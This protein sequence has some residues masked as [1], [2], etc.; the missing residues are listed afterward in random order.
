MSAVGMPGPMELLIVMV[1][2]LGGMGGGQLPI[3]MPPGEPVPSIQQVAPDDCLFYFGS[4]GMVAPD[5][6]SKNQ[7]ELMLAEPEVQAFIKEI[8]QTIQ[9]AITVNMAN[10]APDEQLIAQFVYPFGKTMLT[11]PFAFFAETPQLVEGEN[12]DPAKLI[13]GGFL[14][15]LGDDA[16]LVKTGFAAIQELEDSPK[17]KR[18][19]IG[20]V[21]CWQ[22]I[23]E[24][25]L[26]ITYGFQ[27]SRLFIA[28]GDGTIENMLQRLETPAPKWLTGI[29]K[30]LPVDRVATA[31]YVNLKGAVELFEFGMK[32]E[33]GE[34]IQEILQIAETIGLN[35]LDT[36]L[37]VTG[38]DETGMLSM[39]LVEFD[40]AMP[41][42]VAAL[43]GEKL[44]ADDLAMIPGDSNLVAAV[45]IDK[46]KLADAILEIA[47][48]IDPDTASL[49]QMQANGVAAMLGMQSIDDLLGGIGN[50]WALYNS[51]SEGGTLLTGLTLT[52]DISP[53]LTKQ[54]IAMTETYG[55][56]FASQRGGPQVTQSKYKKSDIF[57][58]HFPQDVPAPLAPSWYFDENRVYI[59]LIPQNLKAHIDSPINRPIRMRKTGG[60]NAAATIAKKPKILRG[61]PISENASVATMLQSEPMMLSYTDPRETFNLF[62]PAIPYAAYM[63]SRTLQD[64]SG[65]SFDPTTVPSLSAIGPHVRPSTRSISADESSILL[66]NHSTVPGAMAPSGTMPVMV[67]LLLPAVQA[68]REAARRMQSMNN[69]KQVML[70]LHN[71]HDVNKRFPAAYHVDD[72]GQP[73]LS[74][75]VQILPFIG[76]QRL[77]DQF[78]LD[79]PW[80]SEHN[81]QLIPLMPP[82]LTSPNAPPEMIAEG[83]TNYLTIRDEDSIFSGPEGIQFARVTDGTSNTIAVV[84]ADNDAAVIWTKPDDL[85]LDKDDPLR[86]LGNLR[87]GGFNAAMCDGSV[88]FISNMIDPESL[89]GLFTKDGG[90]VISRNAY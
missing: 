63:I 8:D 12:P 87:P 66:V 40:G 22:S 76:Q 5:P 13:R 4:N 25:G 47:N 57:T 80:D 19:S 74:W 65:I 21:K 73:L 42:I 15:E 29:T 64:E 1:Q 69:L 81:R 86:G 7:T 41:P 51:P 71:H 11:K 18:V 62:Y 24:D 50:T 84:E 45:K 3:A 77:Y 39:S 82:T 26:V 23:D 59:S 88:R 6:K 90:E 89:R 38:L 83:K 43:V 30:K 56:L 2:L 20:N 32:H 68:S 9:R 37:S 35:R 14:M 16:Q 54:L 49:V 79:E 17:F 85:L 58:L 55:P 75:R 67:A 27:G 36:L 53:K 28:M 61:K 48:A 46:K 72:S 60:K 70:A 78:H 33:G 44:N 10:E 52:A 31:S 34:E